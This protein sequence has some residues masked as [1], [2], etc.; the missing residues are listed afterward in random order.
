M[1]KRHVSKPAAETPL[2]GGRK[3]RRC[4]MCHNPFDSEWVGERV[5]RR[6]K[7]TSAWRE[8]DA[9]A[10]NRSFAA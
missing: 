9:T 2:A 3:P 1:K 8:G 6:C 7:D 10:R 4:L 5:C